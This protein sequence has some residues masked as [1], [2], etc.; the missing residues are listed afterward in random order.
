M[1][2][3]TPENLTVENKNDLAFIQLA[4][5]ILVIFKKPN[6]YV[7][8]PGISSLI[9]IISRT[10]RDSFRGNYGDVIVLSAP[11]IPPLALPDAF[12]SLALQYHDAQPATI[13]ESSAMVSQFIV[14]NCDAALVYEML[15]G[16]IN[17]A[18]EQVGK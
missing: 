12:T 9:P 2:S 17:K 11:P 13:E 6:N 3:K 16:I 5:P 7:M 1:E 10:I 4:I 18:K 15:G 8:S 14:D